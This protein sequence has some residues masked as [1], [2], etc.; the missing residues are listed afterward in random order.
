MKTVNPTTHF[1]DNQSSRILNAKRS[2]VTRRVNPNDMQTLI[3]GDIKPEIGDLVLVRITE[4]G[5]HKRSERIDGRR[6]HIYLDDEIILAYGDRYAPDQFESSIPNDLSQCHMVAAG[7]IASNALS[8]HKRISKPTTVQPIG[9]IA[10]KDGKVLNLKEYKVKENTDLKLSVPSTIVVGT[11]MNA[12]KTTTAANLIHGLSKAGHKVGAMK[13]TGTGA[14]GDLWLMQ[15]SG[16]HT[17]IDFTDA[18]FPTSFNI[19]NNNI[20]GVYKRLANHLIAKGCS[21]IVVEIADGIYQQET[22]F[23]LENEDFK[24]QFQHVLFA[25]REAMGAQSGATWLQQQGYNVLGISGQICASPLALREAGNVLQLPVFDLD[26]LRNP[27]MAR[28]LLGPANN[29][30]AITG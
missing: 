28:T 6:A 14:G 30:Q 4:L 22:Q 3:N 7:G 9:L 2:F 27:H 26:A 15:D 24:R 19:G 29:N 12:G 13:I 1:N 17:V 18:G 11:S 20:L 23:L 5:H 25:A 10:N 21:A 16:A 8:W